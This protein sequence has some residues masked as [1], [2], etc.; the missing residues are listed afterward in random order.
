MLKW[1]RVV[2]TAG[3][4]CSLLTNLPEASAATYTSGSITTNTDFYL[5]V[6]AGTSITASTTGSGD[7][8]LWLFDATGAQV[9]YN[10]D[11]S[12]LMSYISYTAL[13]TGPYRMRAGRCCT[14]D[15]PFSGTN[16]T[17]TINL[18]GSVS[19]TASDV[20]APTVSTVAISTSAGVDNTF[21]SGDVVTATVTWS[22]A[23][24]ITGTPRI[25]IQG[26]SSKYFSYSSG[27]G[28]SST[29]F[30]YTV[31]SGDNDADG[32]SI[33]ANTLELSGGTIKDAANNVATLTHSAVAAS[34]TKL[35]DTTAPTLSS[36]AVNS[37]GTQVV[38]TYGEALSAT[39]A[40][41][42]AFSVIVAGS[43]ASISSVIAS[44]STVTIAIGTIVKVGNSVTVAYT[45]PTAGND[46][47][48]IQ[49][50]GGNDAPSFSATA[51]TNNSAVKQSQATL[52]LSSGNAVYGTPYLL[53]ATGG[54]GLG[55]LS[56]T[57]SSGPC[58]IS[59]VDSLT[60]T[61][62]GTCV[63]VATRASDSTFLSQNSSGVTITIGSGMSSATISLAA[64]DLVFRQAKNVTAL[65]ST[66]GKVTF[67]ANGLFIPGC[68]N[69]VAKASNSF[70]VTC[71]FKPARRGQ[72]TITAS[73]I[74]TDVSYASSVIATSIYQVQPRTGTR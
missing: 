65:A 16:Y 14:Y 1:L 63:I 72:V 15:G 53:A 70:S 42:T 9:A 37:L 60:A 58:T 20:T 49:D 57:V 68:R 55:A 26:L 24:T 47:N 54:S 64:G 66:A 7:P 4:L 23:V 62:T 51:V 17:L 6:T 67:K 5:T 38:L 48:A 27:S 34:L 3:L 35:V 46:A 43:S 32:I 8:T 59:N 21:T 69:L 73:L 29:D 18:T 40:A 50:A 22:E 31:A 52:N 45:D 56:Y 71:P 41:T 10:D 12:G 61:G 13:N 39:T 33:S 28:T 11:Y 36:S 19:M 30:T 25:P 74:P 2:I 44:A